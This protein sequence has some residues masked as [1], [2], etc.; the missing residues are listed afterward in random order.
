[1]L[2]FPPLR[3]LFHCVAVTSIEALR[4]GF[5]R[6]IDWQVGDLD[7]CAGHAERLVERAKGLEVSI[8]VEI[9]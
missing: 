9:R 1:M 8:H 5:V 4:A 2:K 3:C 6:P 7:V